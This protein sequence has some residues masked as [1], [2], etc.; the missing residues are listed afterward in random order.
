M[1]DILVSICCITYNHE[2]YIKDALD[3]F[4][5]QKTNFNFEILIH[6]DASTDKTAEIIREYELRHPN[7]IKPIYQ[8]ENQY[9]KGVKVGKFNIERAQGKYIA[10]CEGDDYW[11]DPYKLQKQVDYMSANPE[12]L[13]CVHASYKVNVGRE[14][15]GE[16]RPYH[17]NKVIPPRDIIMTSG[18]FIPTSSY[19][20]KRDDLKNR[21]YFCQISPVGD[22]ALN[23]LC[24]S[25]GSIHYIDEFMSA[26]R[27][28]VPGSY[29]YRQ[30]R[31]SDEARVKSRQQR[32]R[33]LVEFNKYSN[34]RFDAY[35]KEKIRNIQF[36]IHLIQKDLTIIKSQ[37][38]DRYYS[39]SIK[40]RIAIHMRKYFPLIHNFVKRI[41]NNTNKH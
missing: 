33:M 34:Y 31:S 39:L 11:I 40:S 8:A 5:M 18:N 26:Y 36:E 4:I 37:Y 41:R 7:L 20:Y 28:N 16:I 10:V 30:R 9:S 2:K 32:I 3:S 6:D 22:Y 15:V 19:F 12:C 38:R 24:I 35:I 1:N 27:I 23:L 25:Q 13:M 21:P 17:E 29:L 14:I